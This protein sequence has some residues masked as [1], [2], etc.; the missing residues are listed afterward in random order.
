M[1]TIDTHPETMMRPNLKGIRVCIVDDN[2]AC[3]TLLTNYAASWS[4][5]FQAVE[6]GVRSLAC[7]RDAAVKGKPFDLVILDVTM[8]GMDGFDLAGRIRADPTLQCCRLVLLTALGQRGDA[9]RARE[10]GIAAYLTKPV[11]ETQLYEC[12]CLVMGTASQPH[13]RPVPDA[14]LI[15][16][17]RLAERH[18]KQRARILVAEDSVINQRITVRFL[19]KLGCQ[20][21]V[22][23]N[24]RLAVEAVTHR[25]YDLVLMACQMPEMEGFKATEEIRVLERRNVIASRREVSENRAASS[26]S[27]GK[28]QKIP[29]IALTASVRS[30]ERDQCLQSGMDDCLAKPFSVEELQ[31]MIDHWLPRS[32][33]DAEGAESRRAGA[34]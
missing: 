28:P 30:E 10:L 26:G 20:A 14:D 15:T 27:E 19:E 21:D 18:A 6:S 33:R 3:R 32:C 25:A 29:I 12:L 17:H 7:L 22:V 1:Q 8:P 4:M 11:R 34:S 9:S 31:T 13:D 24:G 2:A 16:S 5:E 23:P